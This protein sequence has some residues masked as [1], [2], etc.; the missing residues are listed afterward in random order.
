MAVAALGIALYTPFAQWWNDREHAKALSELSEAVVVGPEERLLQILADAEDYNRRFLASHDNSDYV[1]Q[2]DPIGDGTMGRIKIDKIKV[3]LPIYHTSSDRVLRKGAGHMDET[4]LP[5]GGLATHAAI[6]AHRGLVESKLFTDL[7][8]VNV[9]DTFTLEILGEALVYQVQTVRI[10][11][12]EETD[13]LVADPNKDLVTLI[14]CDPLGINTE[15]M[16]VT[17]ERVFP[18]PVE[19]QES[20]GE[21]SNLPEFPWWLVGL[22]TGLTVIAGAVWYSR[23]P[24]RSRGVHVVDGSDDMRSVDSAS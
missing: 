7:D 17:G 22:I 14:T 16:L 8:K 12:P 15:R 13:W 5:I 4:T 24:V 3:D 21:P 10:V 1:S 11:A 9:G 2:L 19:A 20:V 18:T 23:R 6:T